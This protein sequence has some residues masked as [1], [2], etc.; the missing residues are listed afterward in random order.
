MWGLI[1]LTSESSIR[2]HHLVCRLIIA[3][4]L[5]SVAGKLSFSR[6]QSEIIIVFIAL[7]ACRF[8]VECCRQAL[9]ALDSKEL[10]TGYELQYFLLLCLVHN[11]MMTVHIALFVCYA[12]GNV[13]LYSK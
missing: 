10:A 9:F 11:N 5:L 1:F 3:V 7:L 4:S 8:S 13:L 2:K 6:P 12:D